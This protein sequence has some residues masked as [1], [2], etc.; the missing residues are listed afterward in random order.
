[1]V[2]NTIQDYRN[3]LI[4]QGFLTIELKDFYPEFFDELKYFFNKEEEIDKINF[5]QFDSMISSVYS[6]EFVKSMY[7][8]KNYDIREEFISLKDE[9]WPSTNEID[10]NHKKLQLK[11]MLHTPDYKFLSELNKKLK[12]ISSYPFKSWIET[13][14]DI[15]FPIYPLLHKI[16]NKIFMDFYD[17]DLINFDPPR[18][19]CFEDG[20]YIMPHQDMMKEGQHKCVILLYL[21]EDYKEG[22]GGEL[23]LDET[24]LVKPE[25]GRISILDF[26]KNNIKHEVTPVVGDFKRCA[27]M[28]FIV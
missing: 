15:Y 1:M 14:I 5:I 21:N 10:N 22:C 28:S 24:E 6:E 17:E 26:T 23:F 8:I 25:F 2:P 9:V 7:S 11:L 12:K 4:T 16:M 20:D 27:V 3:K 18:F 13:A 19:T